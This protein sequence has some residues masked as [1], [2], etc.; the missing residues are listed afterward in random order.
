MSASRQL[1]D[2][3][4]LVGLLASCPFYS[5]NPSQVRGERDEARAVF[6][7]CPHRSHTARRPRVWALCA[8]FPARSPA[9]CA[10][11]LAARRLR[12]PDLTPTPRG[13]D[14]EVREDYGSTARP[15]GGGPIRKR[16]GR[17]PGTPGPDS[18]AARMALECASIVVFA[19]L[20]TNYLSA[21]GPLRLEYLFDE[22]W[23]ARS[24]V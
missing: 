24:S 21:A 11:A 5:P 12:V 6:A 13:S 9:A 7:Q 16:T 10:G 8:A 19:A 20:M 15:A 4:G 1:P 23:A 17:Q 14:G 2:L 22:T 3:P 18:P